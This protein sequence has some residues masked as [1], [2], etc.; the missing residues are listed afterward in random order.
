MIEKPP[1]P[2]AASSVSISPLVGLLSSKMKMFR[3]AAGS[4]LGSTR[5]VAEVW[6]GASA[7][8]PI[9]CPQLPDPGAAFCTQSTAGLKIRA[10]EPAG[11]VTLLAI[12]L[13]SVGRPFDTQ[14]HDRQQRHDAGG[15]VCA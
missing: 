9:T 3:S 6:L 15:F 13:L 12:V 2:C 10:N 8:P 7:V 1:S 4:G 11:V 5:T 14:Q